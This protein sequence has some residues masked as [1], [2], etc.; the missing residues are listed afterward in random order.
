[1]ERFA[2]GPYFF[3]A[4]KV[5]KKAPGFQQILRFLDTLRRRKKKLAARFIQAFGLL[6]L[7]W[8]KQFFAS[9]ASERLK[10]GIC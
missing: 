2:T 9:P 1:L 3:V 7:S 6:R 8:L 4:K 5:S 10:T